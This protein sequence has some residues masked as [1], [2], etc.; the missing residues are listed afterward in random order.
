MKTVNM[1]MITLAIILAASLA[2]VW[3]YP[4]AQ[5]Y[6]DGNTMWNGI[7]RFSKEFNVTQEESLTGYLKPYEKQTLVAIPYLAYSDADL[8]EIQKLIDNGGTL[9][10]MDDFGYGNSILQYL[11]L[12]ARFSNQILLD[13]LF[14]YKNQNMPKITNFSSGLKDAG[15][16]SLTLNHATAI[17]GVDANDILARSSEYS[18][19]D[20]TL[21][22]NLDT[23]EAK[24]PYAIAAAISLNKGTVV[25]IADPSLIINTMV[26][27][28][29]NNRFMTY[30]FERYSKGTAISFD[31][32]HLSRSPLDTSKIKLAYFRQMLYNPY[33]VLIAVFLLFAVIT[34]FLRK[35]E[36]ATI[37]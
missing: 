7:N 37:D 30:I 17:E 9:I 12:N 1:L 36:A 13:P 35:K 26:N 4:S 34:L 2:V 21:N 20:T 16:T 6:M 32:S 11:G 8:A 25:L 10:I 29:D 19:L 27:M 23:D 14:A 15:I 28:A 24:G 31:R 3:L 5:D 18:F 33:V 22:G